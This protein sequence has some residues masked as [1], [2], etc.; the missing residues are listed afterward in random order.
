MFALKC[1]LESVEDLIELEKCLRVI[2][3]TVDGTTCQALMTFEYVSW[4]NKVTRQLANALNAQG[5]H[6]SENICAFLSGYKLFF[7]NKTC[8]IS[9]LTISQLIP[10]QCEQNTIRKRKLDLAPLMIQ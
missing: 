8:S 1:K 4:R 6:N 10:T 5:E 9:Q 2:Y 3:K 7:S